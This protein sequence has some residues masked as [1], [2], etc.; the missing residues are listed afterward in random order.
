MRRTYEYV[1]GMIDTVSP[2]S[3]RETKWQIYK[4]LHRDVAS[5]VRNS[6]ALIETMSQQKDFTEGVKAFMEKR[7]P[8]WTGE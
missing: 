2:G 8:K 3:L 7:K 4:D 1:R 5:S 6:E